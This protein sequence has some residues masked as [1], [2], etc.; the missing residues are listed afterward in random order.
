[1]VVR[2]AEIVLFVIVGLILLE[3]DRIIIF[4]G[5]A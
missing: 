1:M 5:A 2:A 3:L 4:A